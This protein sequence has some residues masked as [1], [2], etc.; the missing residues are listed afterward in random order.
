MKQIESTWKSKRVEE[1]IYEDMT[2][3]NLPKQ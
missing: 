2:I 3:F 1:L